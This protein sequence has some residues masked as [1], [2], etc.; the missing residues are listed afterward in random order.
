MSVRWHFTVCLICMKFLIKF[1]QGAP[2][3]HFT[4][5][6]A[7]DVAG[8]TCSKITIKGSPGTQDLQSLLV[9][10]RHTKGWG[11]GGRRR[12]PSVSDIPIRHLTGTVRSSSEETYWNFSSPTFLS[13]RTFTLH[14][15]F[16]SLTP[17]AWIP[18]SERELCLSLFIQQQFVIY[19]P[20][21]KML[22]IP[23]QNSSKSQDSQS[24]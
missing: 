17:S 14:H 22:G 5:D 2:H 3:F 12:N 19:L 23:W 15:A 11:V 20:G 6:P 13:L 21:T 4:L 18:S 9:F 1:E 10:P 8:P 7:N 24:W 16:P